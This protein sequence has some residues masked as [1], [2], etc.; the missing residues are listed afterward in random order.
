MFLTALVSRQLLSPGSSSLVT[1][2]VFLTAPF[3]SRQ[4]L[5]PGS[6]CLVTAYVFL[7]APVSRQLLSAGSSCLVTANV[8]LTAS[9]SRQLLSP[10]ADPVLWALL[11]S[12]QLLCLESRQLISPGSSCLATACVFLTVLVSR[13]LLSPGSSCLV[14]SYLFLTAPVSRQLFLLSAPFS[15][16]L[17]CSWQLL[18]LNSFFLLAAPVSWA[19]LCSGQLLFCVSTASVSWQLMSRERFSVF[20]V[21]PVSRQLPCPV[22]SCLVSTFVFLTAPVSRQLLSSGSSCLVTSYEFLTAPVSRQLL[23]SGSICHVSAFVFLTAP[24]SRQ[25]LLLAAPVSWQLH[26]LDS[27][28]LTTAL[29]FDI[30]C[31]VTASLFLTA[32]AFPDP[33]FP[34]LTISGIRRLAA[35][36]GN[37]PFIL[38]LFYLTF[39]EQS[40]QSLNKLNTFLH[41]SQVLGTFTLHEQSLKLSSLRFLTSLQLNGETR[42]STLLVFKGTV[43]RDGYFFE[44]LNILISTF[45]VCAD[46]F[47]GFSK[48]VHYLIQLLTFYLLLWNYLLIFKMLAG[49]PQHCMGTR[50]AKHSSSQNQRDGSSKKCN[51]SVYHKYLKQMT[52]WRHQRRRRLSFSSIWISITRV[53][54]TN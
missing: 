1:A 50:W 41:R 22:S 34:P 30:S 39:S 27:S 32:C 42:V 18:C 4:L 7:T 45:C 16:L 38:S 54:A 51:S 14:T 33:G 36:I 23:S 49:M 31:L 26:S 2:L 48:A 3:V 11:C 6:S 15:W 9:M 43:S 35:S 8:F 37:S 44:G 29:F 21:A 52:I 13:Q 20:P 25:L 47:Q 10:V 12:W 40:C 17:L 24:V 46:S 53:S 28:C 5:S 19:L